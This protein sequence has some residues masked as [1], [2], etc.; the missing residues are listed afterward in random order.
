MSGLHALTRGR[1]LLDGTEVDGP[2]AAQI[3]MIFQDANLLPW[4]NLRQ[5]IE[6][7]FEI[8]RKPLDR[9]RVD[10]LLDETGLAGFDERSAR[11]LGRH[12]AARVDRAR[13]RAEPR[14]APDGRAVRR[15]RRVHARRDEPAAPPALAG[16]EKTI[17]FVTHNISEAI[18]LADRVVVMTPRPGRLAHIYDIDLPRPRTIE[19]TFEPGF[20]ELVQ[21]IKHTV[22][23]GGRECSRSSEQRPERARDE[24]RAS[25]SSVPRPRADRLDGP[26]LGAHGEERARDRHD[27]RARLAS[28]SGSSRPALDGHADLRVPEADRRRRDALG[29]VRARLR[30]HLWVTMHEFLAGFAIGASI[31]LVLAALITQKPFAE[32]VIAPYILIMVTTPMLA[33]VPFLRLKIG[34]G[35]AAGHRRRAR[36]GADG[37][38]QLGDRLPTH[39]PGEDRARALVRRLDVPDLRKIR[40]PLALPMIIVGFMVGSIFGLLTA[41]GG[42][43][44]AASEQGGSASASSTSRRSRGWRSSAR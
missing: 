7:P 21:E 22:E 19:M 41:V 37:D 15:A 36:L 28:S 32:K 31:G 24:S 13:A 14:R 12:A 34:F 5:N 30:A 6:F 44:V 17:V 43:M 39:R 33:L 8:K 35:L 26:H 10:A 3:G 18:F 42:E 4:R 2:A 20:I 11:A 23:S 1:I 16:D 27:R 9:A 29:P 38:D 40:F 25:T